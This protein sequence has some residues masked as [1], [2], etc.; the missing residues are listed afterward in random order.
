MDDTME[1]QTGYQCLFAIASE[2][3]GYFTAKQA[4]AC[5]FDGDL[6]A[7]HTGRGRFLRVHR[8][9]YRLRDYP[10]SP[11]EEVAAAWLAAGKD[12]AVIS[13]ESALDLL[14]LSDITPG[15]IHIT[16]P[17]SKRYVSKLPGV[18]VHTTTRPLVDPNSPYAR[19]FD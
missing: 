17:R 12:A 6:L 18:R 16:V 13:H 15:A 4:M 7:H 1:P 10:S 9:V 3:Q 14:D 8:G 2:Q 11:R 5:G 19:A